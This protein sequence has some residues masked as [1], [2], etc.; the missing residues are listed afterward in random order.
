LRYA[1]M[2]S[3]ESLSHM[4]AS[5]RALRRPNKTPGPML[6]GTAFASRS[7]VD[8]PE[9]LE[10]W[11]AQL[12][13]FALPGTRRRRARSTS[14]R[15]ARH[16]IGFQTPKAQRR[17]V[18]SHAIIPSYNFVGVLATVPQANVDSVD[19]DCAALGSRQTNRRM[20]ET[21]ISGR[22]VLATRC[23]L[24]SPRRAVLPQA[25]LPRA[26]RRISV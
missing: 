25:G 21:S 2:S 6:E 12:S 14:A 24:H 17:R 7:S 15:A 10:T 19:S 3:K 13:R 18:R 9:T 5:R 16:T 22:A 26:P 1:T 8:L 11:L 20:P 23:T 4:G